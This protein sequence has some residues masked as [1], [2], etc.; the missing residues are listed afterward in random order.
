[1][2]KILSILVALAVLGAIAA[3]ALILL[4]FTPSPANE[5]LAADWKAEPGRGEYV[6]RAGDCMA[7][8]T[9]KGGEPMAGG[10]AIESP[11]GTIWASN[12][13]P[14]K[15]TGIGSWSMDQFRAAMVD[16]IGGHGQQ[17]YP[18]MPYENYRYM[19]ESDLR[20]LYDYLQTEVKPVHN[21]VQAT[22]LSFP[23]NMR[24]GIRAWNCWLCL[25]KPSS[26]LWQEMSSKSAVSIW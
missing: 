25:A 22:S 11:M 12:I 3:L 20:A 2:K 19:S 21:V 8:H 10:R 23:F 15:E 1:M 5:Q 14:D 24:F 26:S 7:C 16:G 4:P 13:T 9:A 17:L 6:M 18:A